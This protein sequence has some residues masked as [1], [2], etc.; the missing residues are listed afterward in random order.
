EK[1]QTGFDQPLLHTMY[2]DKRLTGVHAVQTL[3]RINR[4]HPGKDETMVLDF[5]N[6]AEDIQNSF[7]PYYD[8]TL[9]K[10]S[11]DPNLLYDLQTQLSA[12]QFYTQ[13]EV[14]R[15]A[16]IY[17]DPKGTQDKLHAALAPATD[18]YKAATKEEQTEFRGK[19]SDYVRLYA[20]VSQIITFTDADLE[21]L[22]VFGRLL[23]RKLPVSKDKLPVEVQRNIDIESYTVKQT[24][25]GK[26]K[27]PRGTSELQPVGPKGSAILLPEDL[28]PLSLIISELNERFGV[29]LGENARA[30][31][32]QLEAQLAQD[33][34]VEA[35]I[36]ANTRD[37]ARLTFEH[38]LNDRLQ[39]LVDSDFKFYK[40]VTDNQEFAKELL[41]WMFERFYKRK[42]A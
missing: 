42:A 41:D 12:F 29:N 21:R 9:L 38:V 20:F 22:Y 32:Q 18:R 14:N 3:S 25:R 17:F 4:I 16:N 26:I 31:I 13:A 23:L 7:E 15:F 24:S 2:V 8:K 40:Q 36:R 6:E 30:S 37:N 27:L 33:P 28:E 11:T 1:F 5:A 10:E 19:L 34:A 39:E 35:S